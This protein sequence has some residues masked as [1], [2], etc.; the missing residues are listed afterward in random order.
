MT[1][2]KTV[3]Q[4]SAFTPRRPFQA[5]PVAP[6]P[7]ATSPAAPAAPVSVPPASVTPAPPAAGAPVAEPGSPLAVTTPPPTVPQEPAAAPPGPT[8]D[9]PIPPATASSAEPATPAAVAQRRDDSTGQSPTPQPAG[10][11]KRGRQGEGGG[12]PRVYAAELKPRPANVRLTPRLHTDLQETTRRYREATGASSI[13][14][15]TVLD[16]AGLAVLDTGFLEVAQ[17]RTTY[18]LAALLK[19]VLQEWSDRQRAKG[20]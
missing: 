19:E 18:E 5:P 20:T 4:Q 3:Q 13:S 14:L 11:E 1:T 17:P 7:A 6:A 16:A 12:R 8:P 9:R 2:K 10:R 15:S